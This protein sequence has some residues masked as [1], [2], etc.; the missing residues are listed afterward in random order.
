MVVGRGHF[1]EVRSLPQVLLFDLV[2]GQVQWRFGSLSARFVLAETSSLAFAGSLSK[3]FC[4]TGF[5]Q[6]LS[7]GLLSFYNMYLTFMAFTL[8]LYSCVLLQVV[9]T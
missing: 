1:G 3:R 5:L 2:S 6:Y 7:L 9:S 8:Q 4:F